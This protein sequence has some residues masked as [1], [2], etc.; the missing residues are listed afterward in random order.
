MTDA[1][2]T[3][4]APDRWFLTPEERGNPFTKIDR[5]PHDDGRAWVAGNHAEVVVHGA[6]YF[7]R[8]YD[9]LCALKNG[10][11]VFFT[12]W[13][14]D[15]DQLLLDDGT[16]IGDV[17]ADLARKGVEVRGLLWRSHSRRLSYNAQD[18]EHLGTR[19]NAAGGEVLLD[20]RVRTFGSHHQKL[21][22]IR[23]QDEPQKDVA[24]VGGIDL[25]HSR[26]DDE[27]HGGDPQVM[28]MDPRYGETPPWHDAVLELR[29]PVVGDL[30]RTFVERWDDDT[31]LDR[32]TPYRMLIQRREHMPRH[33]E[34]LP[35]AFPDP[36]A[37]GEV[38]VQLLRTFARKRPHFPFAPDGE[39]SVARGYAKAFAQARSLIYIEDQY[40][41]SV[42]VA[43]NL[44][45][46]LEREPDLRVIA[47]VPRYPDAD[48]RWNGPPNRI[49]QLDAIDVLRGAGGDRFAVYDLVNAHGTPIYVHAKVCIVDD[50]WLTCGSDNF[51]LRSWTTDTEL[52]CAVIDGERDERE[53]RDLTRHGDGAR[54]LPRDVRLALWRE[55]LGD[56]PSDDEMLDPVSGFDAWTAAADRRDARVRHHRPDPV[57]RLTRLWARPVN[58]LMFDPDDRTRGDRANHRF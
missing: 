51:N 48:D 34:D 45:E 3:D 44:A 9:E 49:A 57:G 47:V 19:V 4:D 46:A 31:P 12:D 22:V 35:E 37:Q 20:Q 17:L 8:L 28:P 58:R 18:N 39:R 53:P 10:D 55:H 52:T 14:G 13:C 30:L 50:L 7:R 25:C 24:Y 41:W 36:P 5:E 32:R 54:R 43:R 2:V 38:A 56:G 6:H 23:H 21:F 29:G 16:E 11:R 42:E 27:H 1:D 40:L 33:P 15:A 26:R